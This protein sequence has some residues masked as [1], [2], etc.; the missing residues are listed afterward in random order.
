MSNTALRILILLAVLGIAVAAF[1]LRPANQEGSAALVSSEE[2]GLPKIVDLGADKCPNCKKM[3]AILAEMEE[4]QAPYFSVEFIDVWKNPEAAEPYNVSLIPTQV[5]LSAS[6][7]ELF[8]HEGFFSKEEILAKWNELG[9]TTG[10][11]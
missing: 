2:A 10:S 7:E 4:S 6:G 1:V 8:R 3:V 11:L 9:I 5:F